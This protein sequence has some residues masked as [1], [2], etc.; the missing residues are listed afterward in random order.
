MSV[1]LGAA[2]AA[3]ADAL[4]ADPELDVLAARRARRL[5]RMSSVT[6]DMVGLCCVL[7]RGGFLS[8]LTYCAALLPNTETS[9]KSSR[10]SLVLGN[11]TLPDVHDRRSGGIEQQARMSP[12]LEENPYLS[13]HKCAHTL[14]LWLSGGADGVVF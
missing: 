11:A 4:L 3:S 8:A 1:I 6:P 9:V 2:G 13:T 12:I 5:A 7:G 10:L 14:S